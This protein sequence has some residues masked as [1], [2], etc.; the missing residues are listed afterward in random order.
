MRKRTREKN[1]K[2]AK[3][4]FCIDFFIKGF[5]VFHVF[6]VPLHQI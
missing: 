1:A 3:K 5:C 4:N 2:K 6:F